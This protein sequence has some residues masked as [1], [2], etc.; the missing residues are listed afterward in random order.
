MDKYCCNLISAVGKSELVSVLTLNI[1]EEGL[2]YIFLAEYARILFARILFWVIFWGEML[3]HWC[4][5]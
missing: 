2:L 5:I 3:I 4:F 1:E